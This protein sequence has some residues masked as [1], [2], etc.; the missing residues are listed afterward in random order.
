MNEY[1]LAS[2]WRLAAP[3]QQVFD[4]VHDSLRW[5]EW[6]P[7][8]DHVEQIEPG[9][10]NGIGSVRRYI[11]KGRLPYRLSFDARATRI[12]EPKLL[13]ASVTGDVAGTGRWVFLEDAGITT[14]RY[15][16]RVRTTRP[17]MNLLAPLTYGVFANNHHALMDKG[18]Q[19]LARR[20][21][22]RLLESQN[23]EL[24]AEEPPH[25]PSAAVHW[26]AAAGAGMVAGVVATVVQLLLWWAASYQPH[27]MLLRDARLAAAIV[28]G[29]GALPPP[30]SFEW[31]VMLVATLVHFALSAAYGLLQAPLA[32]RL[33]RRPGILAGAAFGLAIYVVN[34]Y[35]FTTIF[36]WFEASRDWITAVTHAAFGATAMLTYQLWLGTWRL[37]DRK[38][39]NRPSKG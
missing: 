20:L 10:S 30:V 34:M 9:D 36:P 18:A 3:R 13:E 39:P 38:A 32:A 31:H 11:W 19:G 35:G 6:W 22:T 8:A 2:I 7:G 28:L 1:R 16:W 24:P 27:A 21:G 17:W 14:V 4:I 37:G 29:K 25:A 26:P 12:A 23:E 33:S 5:P 15:E